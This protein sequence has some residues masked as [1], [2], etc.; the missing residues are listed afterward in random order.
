[1]KDFLMD[2]SGSCDII[3]TKMKQI[4]YCDTFYKDNAK[5]QSR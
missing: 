5:N 3:K 4:K 2:L 1:M